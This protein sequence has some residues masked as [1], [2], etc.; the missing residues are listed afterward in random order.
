MTIAIGNFEVVVVTELN[1]MM[2]GEFNIVI[3]IHKIQKIKIK[4]WP[5]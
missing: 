4:N 3:K 1:S 5:H 2:N